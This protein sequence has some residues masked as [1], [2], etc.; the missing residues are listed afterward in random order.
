M[1]F[2]WGAL[3]LRSLQLLCNPPNARRDPRSAARDQCNLQ[4]PECRGV[5]RSGIQTHATPRRTVGA[6][7]RAR[8]QLRADRPLTDLPDRGV[9][10]ARV[11]GLAQEAT[12]L[13]PG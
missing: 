7:H 1:V 11:A 10:A 5:A 13:T 8:R 9:P 2:G 6:Q 3:S 4:Q 12:A